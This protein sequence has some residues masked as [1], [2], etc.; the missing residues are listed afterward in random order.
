MA[1]VLGLDLGSF[2][3][4][5]V[6]FET[7]MRGYQLKGVAQARCEA[8]P[9]TPSAS[10]GT[11]P[12]GTTPGQARLASL[13]NAVAAVLRELPH[14]DQVAV[15]LPG[16]SLATHVLTLPF[17][18]AKKL[19]A[20]LPFEVEA[21]L[22]FDLSEAMFDYQVAGQ[23]EKGSE[24]LVSVV[25]KAELEE[26][27]ATLKSLKADPRIVTHPGIAYQNLFNHFPELSAGV[28]DQTVAA[29]DIGHE[30]TSLALWKPEGGIQ[31][32]RTFSGG[33]LGL[34][35][36]LAT[37]LKLSL[38]E[39]ERYKHQT[40]AVGSAAA[41]LG[42]EGERVSAALTR[43]M[44]PILRE[45]RA[46]L[47]AYSARTHSPVAKVH[48][49]GGTAQLPG[50]AE[51][52]GQGLD[53]P[54]EKLTVSFQVPEGP[55]ELAPHAA[56]AFALALRGQASGAKAP[57]FNLRRGELAFKGDFDYLREKG[58]RLAA[59]A[60]ILLTLLITSGLVR[61][62]LLARREKQVDAKLC[63]VTQRVLGTCEK[64]YNRAL[65]MLKG[66]ESPTA[67][68][69][70][71]SA[72]TLLAELSQRLP[73]D[74]PLKLEQIVVDLE[75]IQLKVETD[76]SKQLDVITKAIESYKCFKDVKEGKIEKSRDGSKVSF[77][78]DIQVECPDSPT[79]HQG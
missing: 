63:E 38:E 75:R 17:T 70:R 57:R 9:A 49:C 41:P 51:L 74:I 1:R 26:L 10:E 40:A 3:V 46:T 6:L 45:L 55:Q 15:A 31:F 44:Q 19:E 60:A 56:Q 23:S 35:R 58:G 71:V 21:Q 48:L 28:G 33:G 22:P 42:P 11:S 76:S 36:A 39:A 24:L 64:D 30:R 59:Y 79:A 37:E 67:A 61:N 77:R 47:K 52:L 29:L 7:S 65:S 68:L 62:S 50:L 14:A 5:G 73:S 2:S 27:L 12:A 66:K 8:V 18:D 25:R 72:V 78:L 69:P 16:P 20:A 53:L 54:V 32:A 13:R 4:K 34:T 43:A